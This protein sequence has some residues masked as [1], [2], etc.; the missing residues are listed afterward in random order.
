MSWWT[1]LCADCREGQHPGG[2]ALVEQAVKLCGFTAKSRF[3]DVACGGGETLRRLRGTLGCEALGVESDPA[4]CGGNVVY[5]RAEALPFEAESFDGVLIECA[6][7]QME[8]ADAALAE[9]A[10]VLRAGGRLIV[11]DLYA[12]DGAEHPASPMG[13]VE[14]REA[15]KARLLRTGLAEERFEDASDAL[16]SL[17]AS[18]RMSDASGGAGALLQAVKREGLK[19]G[20][21][22]QIGI[23]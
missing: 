18:A 20:Y 17:W 2:F 8:S 16:I 21:Y 3:L 1:E 12:R 9:C 22:L 14:S 11:A 19:P 15:L 5:A 6:L 10:R 7:S 4:L 23:K 13:R